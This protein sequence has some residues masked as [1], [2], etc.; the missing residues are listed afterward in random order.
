MTT[1]VTVR[2]HDREFAR[3][4]ETYGARFVVMVMT[5]KIKMMIFI[6]MSVILG[7]SLFVYLLS[8]SQ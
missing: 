6:F 2:K 4:K 7:Y 5:V 1:T 3:G 8:F